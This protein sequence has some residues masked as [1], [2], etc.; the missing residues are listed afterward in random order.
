MPVSSSGHLAVVEELLGIGGYTGLPFAAFLHMGT[1]VSICWCMKK[2]LKKLLLEACRIIYDIIRNLQ[3]YLDNKQTGRDNAY[4]TIIHNNY[5]KFVV[6][7]TVTSIPTMVL[8]FMSRN[9]AAAWSLDLLLLAIGFLVSGVVLLVVDFIKKGHKIPKDM[10]YDCAMWVGICQG[11]SVFP[12][13]SRFGLTLSAG[14]LNGMGMSFA[15]RYSI[16][17]SVPAIIGAFFA[18]IGQLGLGQL[19]VAL[20]FMFLAGAIVSALVGILVIRW[21]LKLV[22]R[23]KCRVFAF[24]SF[25]LGIAVLAIHFLRV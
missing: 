19:N 11:L 18:E 1:L 2:D 25:I 4:Q 16:L 12:G 17:A 13:V 9:L 3:I 8:G 23:V 14:L 21:L 22:G 5:R 10:G 15:I 6:L 20:F 7:L 24:Y